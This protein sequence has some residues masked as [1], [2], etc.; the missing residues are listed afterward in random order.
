MASL[1]RLRLPPTQA[2]GIADVV[3]VSIEV[4]DRIASIIEERFPDHSPAREVIMKLLHALS[5]MQDGYYSADSLTHARVELQRRLQQYFVEE[6]HLLEALS[7]MWRVTVV[8]AP[9]H[10]AVANV[11]AVNRV[12]AL[13]AAEACPEKAHGPG[14]PTSES[15]MLPCDLAEA[16]SALRQWLQHHKVNA[17]RRWPIWNDGFLAFVVEAEHERA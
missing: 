2:P 12:L 1:E 14:G 5:P 13:L 17:W 15:V 10:S 7:W 6:P 4:P 3:S 16:Q 8:E 11:R 9:D